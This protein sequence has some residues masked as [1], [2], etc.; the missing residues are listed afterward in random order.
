MSLR[1]YCT[2]LEMKNRKKTTTQYLIRITVQI[3]VHAHNESQLPNILVSVTTLLQC[4]VVYIFFY[5]FHIWMSEEERTKDVL[6]SEL[7]LPGT[8]F[9]LQLDLFFT[10]VNYSLPKCACY[11]WPQP[12][13]LESKRIMPF[14]QNLD[15]LL[16]HTQFKGCLHLKRTQPLYFLVCFIKLIWYLLL[17]FMFLFKLEFMAIWKRS[18]M[19]LKIEYNWG[20][21]LFFIL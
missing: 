1:P 17:S 2:L 10:E 15:P 19:L 14:V 7:T 5:F 6:C 13:S 4:S 20:Y 9:H 8:N 12:M 3:Q 18:C 21:I 16:H 11:I